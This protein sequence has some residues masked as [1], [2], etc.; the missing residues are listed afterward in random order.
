MLHIRFSSHVFHYANV[1]IKT[2]NQSLTEKKYF[3]NCV[4]KFTLMRKI[5][6]LHSLN[7]VAA[8][9]RDASSI[10]GAIER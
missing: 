4:Q 9:K 8:Y 10:N 3:S 6:T 5:E 2:R 1:V 7:T